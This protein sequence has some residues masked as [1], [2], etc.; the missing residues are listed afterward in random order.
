M[1]ADAHGDEY[2]LQCSS[3]GAIRID[4]EY[5]R[6]F[7]SGVRNPVCFWLALSGCTAVYPVYPCAYTRTR[8]R[9]TICGV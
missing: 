6:C 9:Y 2:A 5:D 4:G 7:G 1:G 8:V 3:A